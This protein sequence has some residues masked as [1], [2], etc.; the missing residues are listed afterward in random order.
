MWLLICLAWQA[1]P[2]C[3]KVLTDLTIN[4]GKSSF[5]ARARVELANLGYEPNMIPFHHL[6]IST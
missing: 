4:R 2:L 3:F 1:Q 5:V 6:A